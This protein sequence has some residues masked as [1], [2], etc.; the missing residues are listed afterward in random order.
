MKLHLNSCGYSDCPPDWSWTT[1]EH[2]FSDYDLWAVFRGRGEIGPLNDPMTR[3]QVREGVAVLLEPSKPIEAR[4]D[5]AYPLFVI[6]AH[7]DFLDDEGKIIHPHKLMAKYVTNSALLR[8]MLM[9]MVRLFYADKKEEAAAFLSAALAEFFLAEPY[10]EQLADDTWAHIIG[11][12]CIEIDSRDKIPSLSEYAHR[13]SYSER[14][15]GKKFKDL[16][17]ISYSDYVK[18]A[19]V[20]KAKMLLCHTD[21]P[22][23][24]IAEE[25]GFYDLGHFTNTFKSAVGIAPSEYRKHPEKGRS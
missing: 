3:F 5:P 20:A 7:F 9:R 1:R 10:T 23:S 8:L 18:N 25:I 17:G 2:A 11:E 16:Q 21:L 12:I 4:H 6:H 24:R 15:I 19:R 14:Y 22:L 13:Y